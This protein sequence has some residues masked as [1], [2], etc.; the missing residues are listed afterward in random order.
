MRSIAAA[1]DAG[2]IKFD[3]E[4]AKSCMDEISQAGCTF[5]AFPRHD[6]CQDVF[7]GLVA[8]GGSCVISDECV[9]GGDCLASDS[10][11][12]RSVSC[13]PGT[14]E[15]GH[16]KVALGAHCRSTLDCDDDAY[17]TSTTQVCTAL[18]TSEGA[19]CDDLFGCT[20]D[21]LCNVDA[22]TQ[23]YTTCYRPAA[24]GAACVAS[25]FLPCADERDYCDPTTNTCA[26]LPGVGQACGTGAACVAYATCSNSTCTA[27]PTTGEACADSCVGDLQCANS[28]CALPQA[29]TCM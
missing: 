25:S 6:V 18:A 10:T 26:A 22:Q 1:V 23:Q 8:V 16:T 7:V 17:C 14:C 15:P 13:C 5:T 20:G 12:D 29:L 3:G 21:L 2:H 28:T 27:R 4:A 19:A 24:R 11:C 9:G